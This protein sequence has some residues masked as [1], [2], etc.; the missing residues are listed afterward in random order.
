MLAFSK[1]RNKFLAFKII[2]S[3]KG[4]ISRLPVM[5]YWQNSTIDIPRY[6]LVTD[7]NI[8]VIGFE[9]RE[10]IR[11]WSYRPYDHLGL[12]RVGVIRTPPSSPLCCQV[13]SVLQNSC[14]LMPIMAWKLLLKVGTL[15]YPTL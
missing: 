8:T 7:G 9:K 10:N 15:L 13:F 14:G 5:T 11:G 4:G 1:R 12:R 2:I 3:W 6:L